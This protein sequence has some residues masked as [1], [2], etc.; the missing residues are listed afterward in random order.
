[1]F[2]LALHLLKIAHD[3]Y[4]VFYCCVLVWPM[5]VCTEPTTVQVCVKARG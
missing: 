5:P 3:S 1:M 2:D 4:V